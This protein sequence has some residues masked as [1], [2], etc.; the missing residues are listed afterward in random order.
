MNEQRKG[1]EKA[2]VA[3]S[4]VLEQ[5]RL[6]GSYRLHQVKLNWAAVMGPH[7]AKYSYVKEFQGTSAI[8]AVLNPVWMNHMFMYKDK[9]ISTINEYCK[10]KLIQDIRFVRSGK[11]PPR[12]VYETEE[13]LETEIF[14]RQNIRQVVLSPEVVR[15]IREET[16]SLP[17]KLRNKLEKLR[18]AQERRKAAYEA[19]HF[20]A[21]PSCGR[22]MPKGEDICFLCYLKKRSAAKKQV[23]DVLM[24]EPWLSLQEVKER[25]ECLEDIYN[26]VRRDCIYRLIEKIRFG[27]DTPEDGL[28][29]ALFVTRRD[30]ADIPEAFVYNL[31]E[32]Y[33]R[34][35]NV[36]PYRR[37]SDG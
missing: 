33:R 19:E 3:I 11:V 25:C 28:R 37:Q 26:E 14:P 10:D 27:G 13:G 2:G 20:V 23:Y 6:I 17:E 31:I 16:A 32:K 4:R 8:I 35:G 15:H 29:L 36:S 24:L 30:P 7:I 9:I 5:N 34:K 22:W 12:V 1:M 18:F 21:C